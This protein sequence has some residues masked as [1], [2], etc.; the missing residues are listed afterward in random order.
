MECA[1]SCSVILLSNIKCAEMLWLTYLISIF[2]GNPQPL[3]LNF[4]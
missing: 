1:Q 3:R 2:C 4:H